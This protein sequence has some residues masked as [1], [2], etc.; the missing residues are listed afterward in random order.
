VV[1]EGVNSYVR[2]VG[3]LKRRRDMM[4][5]AGGGVGIEGYGFEGEGV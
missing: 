3:L 4:D 1:R 5:Y 2:T